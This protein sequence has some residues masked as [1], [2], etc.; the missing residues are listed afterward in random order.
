MIEICARLDG[1]PLAIELAA[2]RVKVLTPVAIL[3][4]LESRLR[5]L[6]GGALGLP[7]RQQTLR[8]A[9]DWS[10]ELLTAERAEAVPAVGSLRR[11]IHFGSCRSG[12]K[13][14]RS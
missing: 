14:W 5:L 13:R 2:A 8:R 1:L 12:R 7:E 9:M 3:G 4:R 6:T 11:R 10:Y